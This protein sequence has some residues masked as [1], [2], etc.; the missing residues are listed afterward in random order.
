MNKFAKLVEL[1]ERQV[2]LMKT[3]RPEEDEDQENPWMVSVIFHLLD[4]S[5][6]EMSLNFATEEVRDKAFSKLDD[7]KTA[8]EFAREC[9]NRVRWMEEILE[10]RNHDKP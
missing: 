9:V 4:G 3:S 2:L 5:K 6:S 8:R 7:D 1:E 10:D